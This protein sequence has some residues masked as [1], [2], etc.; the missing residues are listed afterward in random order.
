MKNGKTILIVEDD[1]DLRDVMQQALELEGYNVL[2]ASNGLHALEVLAL[3]KNPALIFLDIMMPVMDG[4]QFL[5]VLR[6]DDALAPIPVVVTSATA[7]PE[8]IIG[9][10]NFIRKPLDLDAILK[11]AKNYCD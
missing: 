8:E 7:S 11:M 9:A 3:A 4:H 6:N 10:N 1:H 2:S 5:K